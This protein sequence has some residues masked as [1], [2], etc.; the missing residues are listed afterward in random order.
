MATRQ[1]NDTRW[2]KDLPPTTTLDECMSRL[3]GLIASAIAD[4]TAYRGTLELHFFQEPDQDRHP[5]ARVF[6]DYRTGGIG[7]ATDPRYA[8]WHQMA[9]AIS[10]VIADNS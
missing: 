5:F 9:T 7:R 4:F 3:P 6:C 8:D 1:P 10:N 2:P